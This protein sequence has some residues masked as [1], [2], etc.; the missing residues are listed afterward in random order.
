MSRVFQIVTLEDQACEAVISFLSDCH[1][2]RDTMES[3]SLGHWAWENSWGV[4][5]SQDSWSKA[6]PMGEFSQML[7]SG[8]NV[9]Q[10]GSFDIETYKEPVYYASK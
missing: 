9:L 6:L 4:L 2:P 1:W 5:Y 3:R 7:L 8:I 10:T